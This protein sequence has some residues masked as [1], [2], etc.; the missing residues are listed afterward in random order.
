MK[1][2]FN[3][4]YNDRWI[5]KRENIVVEADSLEEL[6]RRVAEKLKELG[7]S[8]DIEVHMWY[9]IY[10]IPTWIRQYQSHYFYRVVKVK[11]D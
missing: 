9:D 1:L 6:D 8:G 11:L 7:Y 2:L 3:L 5:A 4:S 10:T